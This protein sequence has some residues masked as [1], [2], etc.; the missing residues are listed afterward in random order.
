MNIND[1]LNNE[2]VSI[3]VIKGKLVEE[4]YGIIG[5]KGIIEIIIKYLINN[6]IVILFDKINIRDL[7]KLLIIIDGKIMNKSISDLDL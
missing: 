2:I 1:I 5:K 4:K 3:N 7:E 6:F